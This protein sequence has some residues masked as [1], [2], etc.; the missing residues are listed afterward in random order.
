MISTALW[1]PI[2][3]AS[4]AGMLSVRYIPQG[5]AYVL[6]RPGGHL[7]ALPSGLHFALPVL[8]RTSRKVS[9][10]GSCV[11]L[12]GVGVHQRPV[13]ARIYYQILDAVRA[14][15][16]IDQ[17]DAML[18]ARTATLME[19]CEPVEAM[20]L[21]V[22]IKEQLNEHLRGHGVLVTRVELRTTPS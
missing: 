16:I 10:T 7:R 2:L 4:V 11:M 9:L 14:H 17:L 20:R 18:R 21:A 3:I 1:L 12:K 19:A 22:P 15:A 6:R 5:K 13:D 8:E